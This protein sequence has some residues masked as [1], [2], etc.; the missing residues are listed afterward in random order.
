VARRLQSQHLSRETPIVVFADDAPYETVVTTLDS[1]KKVGFDKVQVFP[2]FLGTNPSKSLKHWIKLVPEGLQN[3]IFWK[4]MIT[5][6][7]FRN[8]GETLVVL[9]ESDFAIVDRLAMS[10][11]AQGNCA[12][13]VQDI[14]MGLRGSEHRLWLFDHGDELTQSCLFPRAATSCDFL[15]TVMRLPDVHWGTGDLEAI[16]KVAGEIGCDARNW[17]SPK[18]FCKRQVMKSAPP[19]CSR[20]L[21]APVGRNAP[22]ADSIVREGL[23]AAKPV[24][25]RVQGDTMAR[26]FIAAQGSSAIQTM[27]QQGYVNVGVTVDLS[28]PTDPYTYLGER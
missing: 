8:W 5:T 13:T 18:R 17:K 1:L 2:P 27:Q 22:V 20:S 24:G 15:S 25:T 7:S 11:I 9:S 23:W 12:A 16:S 14:P 4:V 3:H 19:E 28:N 21:P 6:E 10:R 26:P